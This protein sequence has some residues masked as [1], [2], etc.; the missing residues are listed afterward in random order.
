MARAKIW[1]YTLSTKEQRMWSTDGMVGWCRAL[2]AC[3]EDD[4]R[5][6]GRIKYI[7]YD[8]KGS[9]LAKNAVKPLPEK[10]TVESWN[11]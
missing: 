4:A 10:R 1:R 8:R 11:G 5:E 6:N 3:V 7:I 2:E 9:I